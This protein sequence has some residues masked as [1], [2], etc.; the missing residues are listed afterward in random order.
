MAD[1]E[2]LP[3]GRQIWPSIS[4]VGGD[5]DAETQTQI[6]EVVSE[7]AEYTAN[8][9]ERRGLNRFTFLLFRPFNAVF[10]LTDRDLFIISAPLDGGVATLSFMDWRNN[11]GSVSLEQASQLVQTELG[12][13]NMAAF[14]LPANLLSEEKERRESRMRLLAEDIAE[15]IGTSLQKQANRVVLRPVFRTQPE[16]MELDSE[17]CFILMPFQSAFDRLYQDVLMPAVQDA[18]L[19]PLR[20]DQIFSPTPIVE[21]IWRHIASARLVI[22]DVTGR[23]PNVFY[24]LGLAHAAGKPVI[25]LTQS[26]D[27]VPFDLSY[28]RF[29]QY[30]DDEQGWQKL[31]T[32]LKSAISAVLSDLGG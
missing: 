4:S 28:I 9:L 14:Q 5:A 1:Q 21:D 16:D 13:K 32:D 11:P 17:L 31:R 6:R 8:A 19:R 7:F 27:D 2:S 10:G 30:R 3:R 24:E 18:G 25:I 29:F 15:Q 22:A 23:N 26:S 12:W 20:A